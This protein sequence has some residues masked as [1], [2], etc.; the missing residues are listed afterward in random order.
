MLIKRITNPD[1][2]K[3]MPPPDSGHALTARQIELLRQLDRSKARSGTRTGPTRRRRARSCRAR[4]AARAQLGHA[5]RSISSSSRGWSAKGSSPRREADKATL[6][7]RVT[8]DLTGLPPTPA[9]VD[10]FL[11]DRAPDAY[12]KRVDALLQSPRYGERMAVPWLDAAR[13]ADTHGYHIDSQRDMWPW[14]DWVIGAF[15]RNLPFDQFTIEQLAGDLLPDATRDQKIASGFNRN[16]MINF[17]GGAIADE[18]QVEYVV[19]RVEATSTAFMGLTMGCA[20]CHEHKFDPISHKEFY[21]FFAF[22]NNVPERGLDGKRGNAAPMLLLTTPAQQKLLD[23]LDAAIEAAQGRAR[24]RDRRAGPARVGA[25]ARRVAGSRC[26]RRPIAAVSLRTTSST[27][28]SRISPAVF[29]TAARSP[30]IRHSTSGRSG[31]RR[32]STATPRSASA[33]AG[34]FD[35]SDP[36]SLAVWLQAARQ[37][38]D[39]GLPEA[40]RREAPPRVSSGGWTTS[41][42]FDIQRWAGRL[43]ITLTSDA[44]ANA[45]QIRTRERLKFGEWNHVVMSYDGSGKAAGLRCTQTASGWPSTSCATRSPGRSPPTRR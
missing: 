16:H 36:F 30:A 28:A 21:Q 38:A 39:V 22:F 31:G 3:R 4:V 24:R 17:E 37:P 11:A 45:I 29:S 14:R 2:E 43:T 23:E 18:Y 20:R 6:L 9:D 15:N 1:P 12:E 27:A 10:A 19:D 5:I 8:Y 7:R 44:P 13:Y 26:G 42:L 41:Q 35:R 25:G 34:A 40:R 32:R 33:S